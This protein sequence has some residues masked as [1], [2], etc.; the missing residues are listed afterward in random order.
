LAFISIGENQ[1]L[2]RYIEQIN[3]PMRRS[4]RLIAVKV[5]SN[6]AITRVLDASLRSLMSKTM[7]SASSK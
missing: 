7:T 2:T 4:G 5:F 6:I 1:L 3:K